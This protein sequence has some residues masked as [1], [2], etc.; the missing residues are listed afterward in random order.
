MI[1]IASGENIAPVPIESAI[2]AELPIVSHV[3]LIGDQKRFLTC[4]IT[5][6]VLEYYTINK[7]KFKWSSQEMKNKF[8]TFKHAISSISS[9][10]TCIFV[11]MHGEESSP[12]HSHKDNSHN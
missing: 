11:T 5:L 7:W 8:P 4:L 9:V 3:V 6:K 1:V 12:M 2:K 10:Y